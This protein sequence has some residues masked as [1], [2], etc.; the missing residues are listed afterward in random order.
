MGCVAVKFNFLTHAMAQ[1]KKLEPLNRDGIPAPSTNIQEAV[2]QGYTIRSK[3]VVR[4]FSCV[5]QIQPVAE[6]VLYA[7]FVPV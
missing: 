5:S 3:D 2:I 4:M 7:P 6:I 1:G